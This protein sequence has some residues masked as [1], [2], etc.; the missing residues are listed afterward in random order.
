MVR[1]EL[2][3]TDPFLPKIVLI[4]SGD[5]IAGRIFQVYAR[6]GVNIVV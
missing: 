6:A 5:H 2:P 4:L 3:G 1:C